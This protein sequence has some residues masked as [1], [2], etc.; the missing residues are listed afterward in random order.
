MNVYQNHNAIDLKFNNTQKGS[1]DLILIG[2]GHLKE[3]S[4]I[5]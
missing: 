4:M 1:F 5:Y 3:K 2:S